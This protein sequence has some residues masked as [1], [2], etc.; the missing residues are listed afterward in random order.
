MSNLNA[1]SSTIRTIKSFVRRQ[2]RLTEAQERLLITSPYLIQD[3]NLSRHLDTLFERKAQRVLEIG[4]GNGTSLA[5]MAENMPTHDFLGIEVHRP[6]VGHLLLELEQRQLNNVRAICHDAVILIDEFLPESS[7][8][9]IQIFFPDPWHKKRHHKR[10]LIQTE[11]VT[12]LL[13]IMR[14]N[15]RLHIATDWAHYADHILETL[16]NIPELSN[17]CNGF[18]ERPDWRPLTKFEQRGQRLGHGVWDIIF[19]KH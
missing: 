18:S 16:G 7:F 5:S 14:P 3:L 17:S 19:Y 9:T 6:G 1:T 4:F 10:R 12:R 2:G 13:R 11:W 8:D 15:A